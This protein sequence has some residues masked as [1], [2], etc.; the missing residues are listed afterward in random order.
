MR[1]PFL[2]VTALAV[3]LVSCGDSALI[4]RRQAAHNGAG[5]A[6]L[7]LPG[8]PAERPFLANAGVIA[9]QATAS[10]LP[11]IPARVATASML[12]RT[13]QASVAVD[14]LEPA[15]ALVRAL[16]GRVGGYL[17]NTMMQTGR[18]QLRTA[19]LEVK[20]PA[21]HFDDVLVG[22]APIGK[23]E[24]VNVSAQDVGEE[25]VDVTARMANARRLESRLIDLLAARTGKLKDVLDVEQQ[26]ARVR[27]EVERYEGRLRY[28]QAHAAWSTLTISLHEPIPIVGEVG[29]SVMGEAFKQAW[30][31]CVDVLAFFIRSLG[32]LVPLGGVAVCG[33]LA[34]KRWRPRSAGAGA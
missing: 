20:V 26:L 30:R 10:D 28:L 34:I 19:S 3:T 5:P 32:V 15:V 21:D 9:K 12:I 7:S 18:G 31:N 2:A 17:A 27:E 1:I 25:Y 33:W 4:A 6:E 23:L 8:Q 11:P 24:S 29:S 16:A 13:G 22:L 14:S